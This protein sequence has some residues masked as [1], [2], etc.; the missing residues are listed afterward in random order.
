MEELSHLVCVD[1]TS[2]AYINKYTTWNGNHR[3]AR[4]NGVTF[5]IDR[6]ANYTSIIHWQS[7]INLAMAIYNIFNVGQ[8]QYKQ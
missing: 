2:F 3:W 8:R 5:D 1:I 7:A 4:H 6:I